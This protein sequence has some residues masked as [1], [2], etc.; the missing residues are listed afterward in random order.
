MLFPSYRGEQSRGN[1]EIISQDVSN[2]KE[3]QVSKLSTIPVI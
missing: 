3:S 2:R 1:E